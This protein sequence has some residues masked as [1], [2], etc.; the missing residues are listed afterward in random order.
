MSE[1]KI[2][3]GLGQNSKVKRFEIEKGK[4]MKRVKKTDE[5]IK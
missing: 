1:I 5:L 2:N 4:R 3:S